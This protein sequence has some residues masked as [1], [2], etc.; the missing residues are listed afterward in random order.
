MRWR[1]TRTQLYAELRKIPRVL[2]G[3]EHDPLGL[4]P[5]FWS[6]VGNA[7]LRLIRSAYKEKM[8]G[9]TGSDGIK[10]AKLA[11]ATIAK[12]E[13]KGISGDDILKETGALLASLEP[14]HDEVPSGVQWQV[15][16][17]ERAGVTVGTAEPKADW[18]QEGTEYMPRRPI[19]RPDA[20]LP[21]KWEPAVERAM[22][23]AL[24][25]VIERIVAQGP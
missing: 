4:H 13:R 6:H 22:E 25:K 11:A 21:V 5:L 12:R 19:V 3:V 16:R 9:L 17:F 23:R 8:S 15:F 18:H 20:P 14:G 10:W 1:G 2:A 7:V 24:R